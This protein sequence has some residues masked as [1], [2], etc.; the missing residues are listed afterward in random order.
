MK[1][2]LVTV[3]CVAFLIA[4]AAA[5]TPEPAVEEAIEHFLLHLG[6]H[7]L[8]KVAADLTPK[9]LIV[10]T[11]ETAGQWTNSVQTGSDWITG[12]KANPTPVTFREPISNVKV[13]VDGGHLAFVRADFE[14]QVDGKPRSHG[15][16][17]FTLVLEP[18]GWKIAV[19]AYTSMPIAQR[20]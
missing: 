5:Q 19:V 13:T 7:E 8:D 20:R 14:V 10:V 16:D 18:S 15:V 9:A 1:R 6:N 11:R 12:L 2:L 4:P 17:E 3:A